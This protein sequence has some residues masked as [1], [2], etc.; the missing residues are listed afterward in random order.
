MNVFQYIGKILKIT[1]KRIQI[2]EEL[3]RD[4]KLCSKNCP[5]QIDVHA[6]KR[7]TDV[8]C[9]FCLKCLQSCP[10]EDGIKIKKIKKN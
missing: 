7:V 6:Q 10:A 1:S 4:C 8:N 3:C 2:N 9:I 5:M